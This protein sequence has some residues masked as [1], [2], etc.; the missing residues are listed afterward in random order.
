LVRVA[1]A[2]LSRTPLWLLDETMLGQGWPMAMPEVLVNLGSDFA[3][4]DLPAQR[5]IEIVARDADEADRGRLRWRRYSE[6]GWPLT[7]HKAA[8]AAAS[9]S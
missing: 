2:V 4:D 9:G 8:A 3:L 7:H 6:R 5:V 1:D